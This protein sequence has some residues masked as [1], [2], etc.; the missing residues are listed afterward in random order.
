[1]KI[2][3]LFRE[4]L[5]ERQSTHD[6]PEKSRHFSGPFRVR[7]LPLCLRNAEALSHQTLQSSWFF[8][9]KNTLKD[10]LFKTKGLQFDNCLG[11]F[12]KQAPGM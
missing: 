3:K 2:I 1:M 5:S 11:T 12:E 10:E 4:R 6:N 8:L 7:K 9:H